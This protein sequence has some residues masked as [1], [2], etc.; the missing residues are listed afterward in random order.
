MVV[1]A[2]RMFLGE[3]FGH[4]SGIDTVNVVV[5]LAEEILQPGLKLPPVAFPCDGQSL[6]ICVSLSVS[7]YLLYSRAMVSPSIC[8]YLSVYLPVVFTCDGQCQSIC[9]YLCQCLSAHRIPWRW[10]VPVYLK[11]FVIL[12]AH[13]IP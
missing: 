5:E 4:L 10:S 9:V 13:H 7:I 11:I 6:S 8:V 1:I 2:S 3:A 12:S